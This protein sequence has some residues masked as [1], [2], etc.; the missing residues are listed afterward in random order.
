M[1]TMTQ[2]KDIRKMYFEEGKN[3]SQIARETGH[4]RK[5]VRGYINKD[6]WNEEPPKVKKEATFPKLNPYKQDIDTWLIEDKKARRKQR[7]TAKRVYDRLVKKHKDDFDCS[8]RIV[9]EYVSVK[10]KE[11]FGEQKG[12]LPLEHIPG[13][14]QA[15]FGD[16]D[17]YENSRLHSGKYFNLSFPNSNKGY[18]Q[19]YKGE[20]Q[21]CLFEGL[22]TIFEHIGGVPT[23][24]WFDNASTMVT[25]VMKGGGRN[26]TDDFLRF[27][28]HYRFEAA[29]CNVDAGHEKGN[30]KCMIM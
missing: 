27:K 22:K 4:D 17:F 14:A 28:E 1:L 29:F 25:K 7:H 18:T 16:A 10:K 5:T 11:I 8:Y 9:A 15:D 3:I 13:E 24:I 6:D 12:F 2:V 23:R 19:V 30:G 21:E 20:N 26:L